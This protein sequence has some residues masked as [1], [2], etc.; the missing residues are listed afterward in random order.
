MSPDVSLLSII[1][2][3]KLRSVWSLLKH[4]NQCKKFL[5]VKLLLQLT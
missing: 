3:V 4:K 5:K 1:V 2:T